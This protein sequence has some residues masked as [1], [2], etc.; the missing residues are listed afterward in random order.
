M[1]RFHNY[2]FGCKTLTEFCLVTASVSEWLISWRSRRFLE[3]FM[4]RL[5]IEA[6]W[7]DLIKCEQERGSISGRM[8]VKFYR[9]HDRFY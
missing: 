4:R 1:Y 6:P 2:N 9:L 8:H 5:D 7:L 3:R